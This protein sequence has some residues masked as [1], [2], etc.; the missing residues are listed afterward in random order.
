MPKFVFILLVVLGLAGG[1]PLNPHP[2]VKV[3]VKNTLDGRV[4]AMYLE[5]GSCSFTSGTSSCITKE[6]GR[7]GLVISKYSSRPTTILA[8]IV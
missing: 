3:W 1:E 7:K 5:I 8:V 4:L 2:W 6:E